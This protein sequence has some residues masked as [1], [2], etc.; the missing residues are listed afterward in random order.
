MGR[1]RDELNMNIK[2]QNNEHGN[3]KT[4]IFHLLSSINDLENDAMPFMTNAYQ[5]LFNE[6]QRE[7]KV[8]IAFTSLG[9]KTQACPDMAC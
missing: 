2:R 9:F 7:Q 3:Q 6:H 8:I 5:R 1:T 4:L